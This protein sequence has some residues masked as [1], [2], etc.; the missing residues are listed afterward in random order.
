M[1]EQLL[2]NADV[3]AVLEQMSGEGMPKR[4]RT[5]RFR[6]PCLSGSRSDCSLQ[7]SC[8]S[9]VAADD[10][11]ARAGGVEEHPLEAGAKRILI[12][13]EDKRT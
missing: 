13:S 4:V 6:D 2:N 10:A 5:D 8:I 11:G 9:V 12:P 7:G 3:V 1:A